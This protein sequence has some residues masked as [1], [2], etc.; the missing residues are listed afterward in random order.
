MWRAAGHVECGFM[1]SG[2][3]WASRCLLAL[4][5][6]LAACSIPPDRYFGKVKAHPDPTHFTWC[7]SGEPE[8]IDPALGTSTTDNKVMNELYDGLTIHDPEG[9]PSPSVAERWDLSPALRRFAFH[10]RADARWSNGRALTATD[11]VY[12]WARLLHPL[13]ASP[14]AENLWKVVNARAYTAGT[15]HLVMV[16]GDGFA[17]GDVVELLPLP[18]GKAPPSPNLR[19]ARRTVGLS[20]EPGGA[21]HATVPAGDELTIVDV[22]ADGSWAWVHWLVG[23]GALGWVR[24]SDLAAPNAER[25]YQ[26]RALVK[27]FSGSR[28]GEHPHQGELPGRALL[29]TPAVLGLRATRPDLFEVELEDPTHYFLDSTLQPSLRPVPREAVARWPRS[30]FRPEHIITSGPFHLVFWRERDRFELVRSPTFWGVESIRLARVTILSM[31]DT[32]ANAAAYYTSMCDA[33]SSNNM[34]ASW[35]P[36]LAGEGPGQV[37]REDYIRRPF[38]GIYFFIVNTEALANVHLRRAL[39]LALDRRVLP[40]LLKGGQIPTAQFTPGTPIADLTDAERALCGVTRDTPGVAL[41]VEKDRYCY[42]P[43]PGLDY[44]LV[45]ARAEL[46]LAKQELGPRFTNQLRFKF[47]SGVDYHKSIAEWAQHEWKA[48]LGLE[49]SLESQE[50]KTFLKDTLQKQYEVARMG[51]IGNFPDPESE[52]LKQYRCDSPDN[53]TG[54]CNEEFERLYAA[55]EREPDRKVRLTLIKQA[56]AIMVDQAPIIPLF[57]YTQ[58]VLVKPYVKGLAVNV[59]DQPSLRT[60]WI[61]PDWRAHL[62]H[63]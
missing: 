41:I 36:V 22:S 33:T 21:A 29:M 26:V 14:R 31:N 59:V 17:V 19:R 28:P 61:D 13:T 47:N 32:S 20:L 52:F 24:M 35:L 9:H 62:S 49:V 34:P 58:S 48:K 15:A 63:S 16:A 51:A 55:A 11:F 44:D 53:R 46:A 45:R 50:W 60:V 57:V 1:I 8:S 3:P 18:G 38:L 43:P 54:F 2:S 12:A 27:P 4:S 23:D 56:E 37:R 30:W 6:A 7:N 10:L 40:D 42:V 39:S 5:V 25:R